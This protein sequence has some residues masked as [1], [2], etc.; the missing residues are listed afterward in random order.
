VKHPSL[1]RAAMIE[2]KNVE[3]LVVSA[4]GHEFSL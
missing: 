4:W 2:G 3:G 1:K